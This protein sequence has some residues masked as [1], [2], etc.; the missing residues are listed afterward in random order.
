MVE[1]KPDVPVRLPVSKVMS[2]TRVMLKFAGFRLVVSVVP[3]PLVTLI[4]PVVAPAG[5]VAVSCESLT[6][7]N[8]A[9]V[10]LNV[11]DVVPVKFTPLM[12]T[13]VP[14]PPLV[15]VNDVMDGGLETMVTVK[16][17]G[18]SRLLSAVPPGVVTVTSPVL[19]LL[20]TVA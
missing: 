14:A 3:E 5:T 20:P 6:K 2:F 1:P 19:A 12:V 11:T 18:V 8:V 16:L 15:G 10:P 9:E 7:L 4:G 17:A 13:R